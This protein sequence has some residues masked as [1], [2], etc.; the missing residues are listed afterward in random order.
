MAKTHFPRA[1]FLDLDSLIIEDYKVDHVSELWRINPDHIIGTP[2]H[3]YKLTHARLQR[4]LRLA[5]D[6][7][8]RVFA[9][10]MPPN[11][12]KRPGYITIC[13]SHIPDCF[14]TKAD[15]LATGPITAMWERAKAAAQSAQSRNTEPENTAQPGDLAPACL[16]S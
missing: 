12:P 13:F 11:N 6:P 4:L 16:H 15:Y 9:Y 1:F 14:E 10:V 5:Q 8:S 2:V 7:A 3:I